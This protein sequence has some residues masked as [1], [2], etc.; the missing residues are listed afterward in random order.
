MLTK[1]VKKNNRFVFAEKIVQVA[2]KLD[3]ASMINDNSEQTE[4]LAVFEE[5]LKEAEKLKKEI[6]KY[7]G[8]ALQEDNFEKI[9]NF[10][11]HFHFFFF[12]FFN[13]RNPFYYLSEIISGT[14]RAKPR[15]S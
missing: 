1:F 5:L 8:T 10:Y 6:M 3:N 14:Q 13:K 2:E 15:T 12:S 7:S 4:I 9:C 11:F